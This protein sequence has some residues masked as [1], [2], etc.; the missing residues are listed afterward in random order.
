MSQLSNGDALVPWRD[1]GRKEGSRRGEEHKKHEGS[2]TRLPEKKTKIKKEKRK[3]FEE[4]LKEY[5]REREVADTGG[6]GAARIKKPLT[7][8]PATARVKRE[9]DEERSSGGV[10]VEGES[11]GKPE[12]ASELASKLS[13]SKKRKLMGEMVLSRRNGDAAYI[14]QCFRLYGQLLASRPEQ[15]AGSEEVRERVSALFEFILPRVREV[16]QSFEDQ[17]DGFSPLLS[18][19]PRVQL[20][21]S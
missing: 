16:C 7:A 11:A 4:Q 10:G 5:L 3:S 18:F 20:S 21:V 2:R 15:N 1:G 13:V 17:M 6:G 14:K 9:A 19:H 8:E 12:G